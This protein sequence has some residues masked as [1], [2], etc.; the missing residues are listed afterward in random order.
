MPITRKL[1]AQDISEDN[2]ILKMDSSKRYIV[3]NSEDWQFL[4]AFDS[5]FTSSSQVI[6]IAGELDVTDFNSIRMTAYLY[7][8]VNGLIDNSSTCIFNFYKVTNPS[9]VDSLIYTTTGTL[10]PNAYYL[11]DVPMTLLSSVNFDGGDTIMIEAIITRLSSTYRDRVYIN[12]LGIYDSFLRLKSKVTFLE[13][14]KL[15]E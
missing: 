4:F 1:V 8:T 6:K 14:T 7:N 13:L 9:W 2:Q 15:D 5:A 10:Q 11:S 12:H 3:S